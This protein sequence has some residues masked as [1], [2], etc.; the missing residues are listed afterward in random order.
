MCFAPVTSQQLAAPSPV[1]VDAEVSEMDFPS[2]NRCSWAHWPTQPKGVFCVIQNEAAARCI[3]NEISIALLHKAF[4]CPDHGPWPLNLQTETYLSSHL[5]TLRGK[6]HQAKGTY[7]YT[8]WYE[9][10]GLKKAINLV[11][12]EAKKLGFASAGDDQAGYIACV[13]WER[14]SSPSRNSIR[15]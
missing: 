12:V 1:E 4:P 15:G 11:L 7:D 3:I 8:L 13:H 14:K 6:A 2:A 9:D 5:F 10:T